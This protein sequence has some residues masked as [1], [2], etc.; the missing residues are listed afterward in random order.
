M[1]TIQMLSDVWALTGCG[2]VTE[3]PMDTVVDHWI[4]EYNEDDDWKKL[5]GGLVVAYTSRGY[6]DIDVVYLKEYRGDDDN[7]D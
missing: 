7:E 4:N 3:F 5:D 2:V 1:I 6:A